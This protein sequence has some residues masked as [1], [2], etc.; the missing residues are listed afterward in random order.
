MAIVTF[1]RGTQMCQIMQLSAVPVYELGNKHASNSLRWTGDIYITSRKE[2][3]ENKR[4]V[5]LAEVGHQMRTFLVGFPPNMT[6]S[7]SVLLK[8]EGGKV[9]VTMTSDDRVVK[10]HYFP[11]GSPVGWQES[12]LFE[13][14]SEGSLVLISVDGRSL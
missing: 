13:M 7:D 5:I 8:N 4:A 6:F 14:D 12:L 2:K 11:N 1:F 9:T 10:S 3:R